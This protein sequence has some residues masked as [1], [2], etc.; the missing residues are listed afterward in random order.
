LRT[1]RGWRRNAIESGLIGET[2][3]GDLLEQYVTRI[4]S[5][6]IFHSLAWPGSATAD[7]DHAVLCGRRLLLIDSKHWRPGHY[8]VHPQ[9]GLLQ[10]GRTFYGSRVGLA[11]AVMA[12]RRLLPRCDVRGVVLIHPNKQGTV[13][14]VDYPLPWLRIFTTRSFLKESCAWLAGQPAV[15][16][17]RAVAVLLHMTLDHAEP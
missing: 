3:T 5:A 1:A 10:N 7:V 9:F 15:V 2:L 4:P 12:Y 13:S 11:D 14:I 16:D 8:T 17:A 6:R